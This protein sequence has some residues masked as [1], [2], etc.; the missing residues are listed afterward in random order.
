MGAGAMDGV[1]L[2]LAAAEA[3]ARKAEEHFAE[4]VR[5][6]DDPEQGRQTVFV[7]S[8]RVSTVQIEL[9]AVGIFSLFEARMQHHIPRGS[10]FRQLWERLIAADQPELAD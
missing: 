6:M 5:L 4:T 3:K 10:F 8:L 7:N 2:L 1:P 9:A